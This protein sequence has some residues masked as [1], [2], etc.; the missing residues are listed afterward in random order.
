MIGRETLKVLLVEDEEI[1]RDWMQALLERAGY[2]VQAASDAASAQA[3]GADFRPHV[4]LL[5]LLPP[6]S[7]DFGLRGCGKFAGR[8]E[9]VPGRVRQGAGSLKLGSVV[10]LRD[11]ILGFG[12]WIVKGGSQVPCI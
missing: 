10:A 12:N 2:R 1:T 4:A 5:D 9:G 7:E 6:D 3:A 11:P 8:S